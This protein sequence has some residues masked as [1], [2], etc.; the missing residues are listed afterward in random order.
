MMRMAIRKKALKRWRDYFEEIST[1]EFP[2]PAIPSTAPTHGPVQKITVEEI[3][4]A[5]KKMRPGKAT[6]PD[7]VAADL[8]KSKYWYP[9]EWLAKFFN[10]V[11]AEKKVPECWR[12]STTIPI[13]KKKGSPADC[14]NYRPIRLLPHSM[15]IFE[16]I[17]DGR[18]RDIV[19]LSSNQCGFV[20][21]CGTVDAIHATRLLIE[22]HREKQK[23]V[24]IAFLDLEKAFDRVPR[25][26]PN[27]GHR[28]V[29]QQSVR[30]R[31]WLWHR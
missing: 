22:K 12:Q 3:E 28:P 13:W 20:A 24:H 4:A 9:A 26:A 18:I 5:L 30:L 29:V 2:H 21:G 15:K 1:V 8:W 31:G 19:Q 16:R 7:D 27:S 6:G 17:V 10:Q 14:S 11:V 23:A 25:E